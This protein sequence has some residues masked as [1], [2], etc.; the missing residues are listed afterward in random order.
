MARGMQLPRD[1]MCA[2]L[3]LWM[4][5]STGVRQ[6]AAAAV[7]TLVDYAVMALAV[8]A[9]GIS[10]G[11][12][13]ALGALAGCVVGFSTLRRM[14]FHDDDTAVRTQAIRYALVSL[15]GLTANACGEELLVR[16]GLSYLAARPV[17]SLL[18]AVGWS[19]P[20]QRRF[21]FVSP[22]E[23]VGWRQAGRMTLLPLVLLAGCAPRL[24][25]SVQESVRDQPFPYRTFAILP[26]AGAPTGFHAVGGFADRLPIIDEALCAALSAKGYEPAPFE[27]ADIVVTLAIGERAL[28]GDVARDSQG[29]LVRLPEPDAPVVDVEGAIVVDAFDAKT[30][31]WVWQGSLRDLIAP[32][33]FDTLT[34]RRV[35][36]AALADFPLAGVGHVCPS[37]CASSSST[38]LPRLASSK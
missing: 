28:R 21:V 2:R 20:M 1:H 11:A 36:R 32:N 25:V 8:S 27:R 9:A 3:L 10:A 17:I 33:L 22:V 7:A 29:P 35:V 12:A 16:A 31:R 14:A 19:F 6:Q 23:L 34:L 4:R 38:R 5:R 30:R 18:V 24:S 37:D 26:A 13:T 15:V